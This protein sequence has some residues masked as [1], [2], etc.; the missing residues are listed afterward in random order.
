V[1]RGIVIGAFVATEWLPATRANF[2][3]H[4]RAVEERPG[5]Y[6]FVGRPADAADWERLVGSRGRRIIQTALCHAQNPIRYWGLKG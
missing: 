6:G 2:P 4:P 1:V 5:R 3:D